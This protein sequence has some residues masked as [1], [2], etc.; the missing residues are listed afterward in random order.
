MEAEDSKG[1]TPLHLAV[2]KDQAAVVEMLVLAGADIESE[3][4]AM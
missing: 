2:E 3:D 4:K 1:N